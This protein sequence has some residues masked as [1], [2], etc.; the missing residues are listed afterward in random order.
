MRTVLFSVLGFKTFPEL[1]LSLMKTEIIDDLKLE[2]I[3]KE[4]IRKILFDYLT[5]GT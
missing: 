1:H 5:A 2:R 4:E 3:S